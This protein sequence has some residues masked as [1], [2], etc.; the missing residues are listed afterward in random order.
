M[1]KQIWEVQ[2][3]RNLFSGLNFAI[4]FVTVIYTLASFAFLPDFITIKFNFLG[5]SVGCFR[6]CS[7]F[8]IPLIQ[9]TCYMLFLFLQGKVKNM[10]SSKQNFNIKSDALVANFFI[11]ILVLC[12]SQMDYIDAAKSEGAFGIISIILGVIAV[13]LNYL[14]YKKKLKRAEMDSNVNLPNSNNF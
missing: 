6:R 12:L 5:E 1:I 14:Y 3:V 7:L 4:L 10:C 11:I 13:L 9:L 8:V 2:N